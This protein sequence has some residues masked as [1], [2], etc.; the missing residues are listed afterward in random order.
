MIRRQLLA[1]AAALVA[2]LTV[3]AS[4]SAEA[5]LPP[6]GGVWHGVASGRDVSD[7]AERTGRRPAVWQHWIRWGDT[8]D[9]A[10]RRSDAART[11]VMLHLSTAAAQHAPGRIS[12]GAIARG[13]GDAYLVR[14]GATLAEHGRPV[15]LRLM[16]E[17]NNCD[18]AY[19]S[20]D[21][22]GRPRG[23]DHRAGRYKQ[24]FRRTV[25]VLRGGPVARIDARLRALGLPALR[26]E[27]DELPRPQV[28]VMWSPMTGGSPMIRA[29]RPGAFWPGA[30]YVDWVGTSFYS[31]FPNFHFLEPF[32]RDFA[33]RHR[34]P[35]AFGEWAMWGRD[36]AAFARRLLGWV[37]G[38]DRVRMLVYNQ[39]QNPVGPFRLR[40]FPAAARVLRGGLAARR[41]RAV[42]AEF[43]GG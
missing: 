7:F 32:Y 15:Y 9:Y 27:E 17:M 37:R 40:R 41:Y 1:V 4:S 24:A 2:L 39:G 30:R 25:L 3:P 38:H 22:D 13:E 36:D 33:V 5:F 12:P 8:F 11:R 18:L 26:T 19:S 10:L 14:L 21:C 16:A 34:K 35:F 43:A 20:H 28:A 6:G 29:L 31:R 42:P 23:G